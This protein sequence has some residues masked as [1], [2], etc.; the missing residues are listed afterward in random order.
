[1]PYH[2]PRRGFDVTHGIHAWS[3]GGRELEFDLSATDGVEVGLPTLFDG[4]AADVAHLLVLLTFALAADFVPV[5]GAGRRDVLAVF[6]DAPVE[7]FDPPAGLRG[8]LSL[9]DAVH[10][11]LDEEGADRM[12]DRSVDDIDGEVCRGKDAE[13]LLFWRWLDSSLNPERVL[14]G[15][16]VCQSGDGSDFEAIVDLG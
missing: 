6:V 7:L 3:D 14:V 8:L 15:D 5:F 9:H 11:E 4:V 13:R 16:D 10:A 2:E 1:M 12:D